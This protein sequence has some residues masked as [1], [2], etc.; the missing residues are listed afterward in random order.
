MSRAGQHLA[1]IRAVRGLTLA[2][3]AA[4]LGCSRPFI[5][6]VEHGYR[7]LSLKAAAHWARVLEFDLAPLVERILQDQID[8]AELPYRVRVR[9]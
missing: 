5:C 2:Q 1:G 8:L 9:E 3:Q 4:R 6:D 7:R